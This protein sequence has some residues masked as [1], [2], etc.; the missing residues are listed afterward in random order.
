MSKVTHYE[1]LSI[2]MDDFDIWSGQTRLSAQDFKL[3]IGG[4]I[5]PEKLAQLG[6]KKIC[7][8]SHLKG[9]HRLKT[10]T[11]RLLMRYGMKF[12][13]GYAVPVDKTNEICQKLDLIADEYNQLKRQ[14]VNNYYGAIDEWVREN[15]GY[16]NVIRSG[17]LP[18][19]EV[20]KRIGFQYQVFMIQPMTNDEGLSQN[21]D[22]KVESLGS[23]LIAEVNDTATKFYNERFIGQT[24]VRISTRQTLVNLRDKIDGLSFLNGA[25]VP[26]VS[27]LNQTIEGYAK[28]ATG[29]YVEAPF[30]YQVMAV[31][32]I[33]SRREFI[34]QFANGQ[35]QVETL[36]SDLNSKANVGVG[37]NRVTADAI[38]HEQF[39]QS[40]SGDKDEDIASHQIVI[41]DSETDDSPVKDSPA[42]NGPGLEAALADIDL[43]FQR[44]T[45]TPATP[46]QPTQSQQPALAAVA[47]PIVE[48][49][50]SKEVE[51]HQN[52]AFSMPGLEEDQSLFF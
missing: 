15:P 37:L 44:Q 47:D 48:S 32:S 26:L 2:I 39:M 19:E 13:N 51:I 52:E 29:H 43:F 16:E 45:S 42:G 31:V 22:R 46:S 1:S 34:E 20:E 33:L 30:F 28:H 18:V 7:D 6:S 14:F 8:P 3:G 50:Q 38:A 24:R 17:A 25:L 12:M 23:D 4:E 11:D 36:A 35:M 40:T 9:F 5:P 21:L 49:A 41:C 27:L 10:Q